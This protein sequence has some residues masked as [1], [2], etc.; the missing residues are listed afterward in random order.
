MASIDTAAL[1]GSALSLT[2]ALAWNSAIQGGIDAAIPKNKSK[3]VSARFG[4]A[5][6]ITFIVILL[7]MV[8]TR[9]EPAIKTVTGAERKGADLL[10]TT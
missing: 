9:I 3:S 6:L 7:A 5:I 10:L 1:I 2:A 8:L 4:Y